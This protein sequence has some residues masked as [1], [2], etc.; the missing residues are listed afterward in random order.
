MVEVSVPIMHILLE[1][2]TLKNH[3]CQKRKL[4]YSM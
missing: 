2:S 3:L 1:L 4:H